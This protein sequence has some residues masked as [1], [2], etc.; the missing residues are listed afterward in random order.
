MLKIWSRKQYRE[1]ML[2]IKS[3]WAKKNIFLCTWGTWWT[4]VFYWLLSWLE[5]HYAIHMRNKIPVSI[6][7]QSI[8]RALVFTHSIIRRAVWSYNSLAVYR[9]KCSIIQVTEDKSFNL[10]R[11]YSHHTPVRECN[12]SRFC[13]L[14]LFLTEKAFRKKSKRSPN[15]TLHVMDW[16]IWKQSNSWPWVVLS[17]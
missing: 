12:S 6:F 7:E 11:E 1:K 10:A 17:F 14:V 13:F 3:T 15:K 8:T 4:K 2:H 9:C 5:W 16:S